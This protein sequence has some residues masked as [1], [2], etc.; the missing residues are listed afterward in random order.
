MP[1]PVESHS[2]VLVV[3]GVSGCGK[4]TI[5]ATLAKRLGWDY[6]EGDAF[7]PHA[8]VAKLR[9][10]HP[11]HDE[12]REPWLAAIA[13]WIDAHRV[14]NRPGIVGCSAL[15]R[16]Y[17]DFLRDGRPQSWFVYLRVPHGELQRRVA[18][19]HHEYMPAS[20]LESQLRTLEE[21]TADEPRTL[22]I[23]AA[24]TIAS[25]V[26]AILRRLRETNIL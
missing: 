18:T 1:E 10:G 9:A 11:L 2:P 12:D 6:Q 5:G 3:M 20:L 24:G 7:H 8:N 22:T 21:P 15:K 13:G 26:D 4:T 16:S 23:D 19:R 25:T 14:R 17:R